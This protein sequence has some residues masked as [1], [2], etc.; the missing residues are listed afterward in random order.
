[1]QTAHAA[2]KRGVCATRGSLEGKAADRMGMRAQ[3]IWFGLASVTLLVGLGQRSLLARRPPSPAELMARAQSLMGIRAQGEPA[4]HLE[5]SLALF[6]Y[7][8]GELSG[9][10]ELLWLSPEEWRETISLP[11]YLEDRLVV[12]SKAWSLRSTPYTP[13]GVFQLDQSLNYTYWLGRRQGKRLSNTWARREK[14][15]REWCYRIKMQGAGRTACFDANSGLLLSDG[16]S[17]GRTRFSHYKPWGSKFFPGTISVF[18]NG[19]RVAEFRAE[20]VSSLLYP[21]LAAFS[22]PP[23]AKASAWCQSPTP[24]RLLKSVP[25]SYPVGALAFRAAGTVRVL[26][27]IGVDG[28]LHHAYVALTPDKSLDSTVLRALRQW[29]YQPDKCQGAPV[30]VEA[31]ID[32]NFELTN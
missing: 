29:R 7:P 18:D 22:P 5:G 21:G 25:P 26:A 9:S 28:K 20:R 19:V 12:G 2:K 3:H 4:F 24:G 16:N 32:V 15:I 31:E 27:E 10:Y 17:A 14:G 6:G 23:G 13:Y 1:M 8:K 11:G 30:P